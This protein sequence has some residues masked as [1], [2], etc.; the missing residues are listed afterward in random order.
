MTKRVQSADGVIHEF[1]DGTPDAAIDKAMAD[2]ARQA[3]PKPDAKRQAAEKQVAREHAEGGFLY[4][5]DDA[6]RQTAKGVPIIGGALDELNAGTAE[7]FGGDYDQTLELQRARDRLREGLN[8]E[9][10][11]GLNVF[12]GTGA[13]LA[14][15]PAVG[16]GSLG[17][18][19]A[20]PL[21][22]RALVGT[23][24]GVP[25]GA[26]DAFTRGEGGLEERAGQAA[27]GGIIGG[28]TGM[29][30]PVVGQGLASG[31]EALANRLARAARVS[32]LGVSRP[33]A[34]ELIERFQ[35]DDVLG[36]AAARIRAGGPNAMLADTGPNAAGQLDAT[37]QRGGPGA[38]L[39]ARAVDERASQAS[40]D[41]TGTLNRTFGAPVGTPA[42]QT[43]I[44]EGTAAARGQ[45]YDAAYAQPINYA[46][47]RGRHVEQLLGR[48]PQE[49]INQANRLMRAEGQASRQIRATINPD[50]TVSFDRL[51]DVRQLDYITR[52]L[53]EVAR[54][55][56]GQGALGGTT[57]AG[58]IYGNLSSQ[59]RR[60]V[61]DLVPEYGVALDTAADPIRRIQA[62]G[63]DPKAD[64]M[65]TELMN[66]LRQ[67]RATER[68]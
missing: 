68:E 12:G 15:A 64:V 58:R 26:A 24:I 62:I 4:D 34:E 25:A 48:V 51:P 19:T 60:T 63:F 38:T 43:A 50:G 44:R 5:L 29:A 45:A 20:R 67:W 21:A 1:P 22:Q 54:G 46:D 3:A 17:V 65:V 7:L 27:L 39:A 56:E 41:M 8:P 18:N 57:A 61:R 49:A 14:A 31:Y 2:Y 9:T 36:N 32:G 28:A 66:R 52:A 47:P 53:N 35:G 10:S 30:A 42:R 59:I 23:T 6:V 13:V 33:V 37:I 55:A 16:L 40:R 11:T